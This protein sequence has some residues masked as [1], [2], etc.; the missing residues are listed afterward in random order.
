[1]D[2]GAAETGIGR[3]VRRREDLRLLDRQR[4]V[5][6]RRQP[7]GAGLCGDGALAACACADP[8]HRHRGRAGRARGA[9]GADRRRCASPT[10][11]TRCRTSP[12]RHPADISIK[13]KDGSPTIRPEQQAIVGPEVCHVG[14]IV[15]AVVATIA[16]RREGRRRTGRGRLRGACRRSRTASPPPS[17]DAPRARQ[18]Q[19]QRH[20]RRRGRR[21]GGDRGGLRRAPRMSSASRPGCSASPACRWSRAPRSANTTPTTGRYTLHAGAGGAVSPRRDLAMVLGVPPEQARVVMHDVGG[22]FGT[23]G[24]FN[25]EFAIVAWA[26]RRVGRP[27]KWTCERSE[28][29]S[30]DHQA[31]DLAVTAELALDADGT[32]LAMRGSNLVNQGAY[33]LAFGSLNKGVEIMSS[34]YHV[35]AVLFPR[36]RRADQHRADPPLSQLRPARGHV[37]HGAADRPGGA[38]DRHR[39]HRIAP[40]QPRAGIDDAVHQPVRHGLRQ[41]RLPPG[42][43]ARARARRL[44]G[45]SGAA[46]RGARAAASAA[47]SA[48]PTT[49]I[50]RPARRASGPRSP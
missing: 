30:S 10:G 47:A 8:Q 26:A 9:G 44:G 50:P 12:T 45:L 3:P 41:R 42:H 1:M 2:G 5:Q 38:P 21:R 28:Y 36:P 35:P 16:C 32:F 7:A 15:A 34:I 4:A 11:S 24:G 18:D 46:R 17:P 20:P 25:P 29:F 23:R 13:N 49:S 19:P 31:R 27:V 6:R 39:P 22:N 14:E 43:G 33:A 37:R 40:A 48:S